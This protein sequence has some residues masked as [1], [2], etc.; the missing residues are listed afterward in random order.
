M[1]SSNSPAFDG[2]G[3]HLDSAFQRLLLRSSITGSGSSSASG[4]R[5]FCH[6]MREFLQVDGVYYWRFE[7]PDE[8][9]GAE[10]DGVMTEA[11]NNVRIRVS[12]NAIL[13]DAI[14]QRKTVYVNQLTSRYTLSAQ[15]HARS[16][17][18]SP[19]M[20][21]GRVIGVV[22]FLH[23]SNPD[24][25]NDEGASKATILTVQLGKL[26]ESTSSAMVRDSSRDLAGRAANPFD[27]LPDRT[28]LME[29][30]AD[31]LRML[32]RT[33]LVCVLQRQGGSFSLQAVSAESPQLA[34]SVR[35]QH[36]RRG[37][38][39]A[40][41]L[42]VRAL[43]AGEPITVS[44]DPTTYALGDLI[45]SGVLIAAPYRSSQNQGAVLIYPRREGSFGD[46][47][48]ALVAAVV[49]FAAAALAHAEIHA[50]A[51]E[52]TEEVQR[53]LDFVSELNAIEQPDVLMQKLSVRCAEF[54]G[55]N[56]SCI[57]VKEEGNFHLRWKAEGGQAGL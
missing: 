10:A 35:T 50:S 31:R 39:F 23:T 45:P 18:S 27:V 7:P 9:V 49:G 4:I 12:E 46:A 8:L 56:G 26:L 24:F 44:I 48:K 41:D 43:S 28:A 3:P 51:D 55:F 16:F 30:L 36:D 34:T 20:V 13:G 6:T 21:A 57:A 53:L 15:F 22:A 54:L 47:D 2:L 40:S 19:L 17:M 5:Q 32:L 29:G 1:S 14:Q 33:R 37:T 25:F 11:F 38:Q 42:A 52:H